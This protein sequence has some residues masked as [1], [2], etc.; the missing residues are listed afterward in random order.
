MQPLDQQKHMEMLI[1][2]GMKNIQLPY[3]LDN[4]EEHVLN[5]ARQSWVWS[6]KAE[7]RW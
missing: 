6:E 1:K 7:G 4:D 2:H 5:Q 3:V